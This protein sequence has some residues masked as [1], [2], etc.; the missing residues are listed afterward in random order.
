MITA[1][2]LQL[3]K[4][5]QAAILLR[6]GLEL[7][8][9]DIGRD[10]GV[11]NASGKFRPSRLSLGRFAQTRRIRAS[12][13]R[14]I[15]KLTKGSRHSTNSKGKTSK[16]ANTAT[17]L[18]MPGICAQATYGALGAGLH[19]R[20]TSQLRTM[21]AG[22]AGLANTTGCTTTTIAL[23]M[24][25][26]PSV[27]VKLQ[28]F[29]EWI[30]LT[31]N[32]PRREQIQKVWKQVRDETE[33]KHTWTK[34]TGPLTGTVAMLRDMGWNPVGP[35]EWVDDSDERH[36]WSVQNPKA[37]WT[38]FKKQLSASF[39]KQQWAKAATF[40]NGKGLE[41]G[42]DVNSLKTLLAKLNKTKKYRERGILLA[43][44]VD[45]NWTAKRK[46]EA[47]YTDNPN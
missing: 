33:Q 36:V 3:A 27:N 6:T 17:K 29:K 34:V 26:D 30:N 14:R 46:F 4:D 1:S 40:R 8:I 25:E 13:V 37:P 44:A 12:R 18:V 42:G 9:T 32:H 19:P 20:E 7:K 41:K 16:K 24:E 2:S 31:F 15:A 38:S 21:A 22:A 28:C 11:G 5:I 47:G 23:T 35:S 39:W 43:A 10:L 45:A